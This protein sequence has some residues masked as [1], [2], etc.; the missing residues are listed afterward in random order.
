MPD[1][2]EDPARE[3]ASAT[4]RG[5]PRETQRSPGRS[6]Q[7]APTATLRA[8]HLQLRVLPSLTERV[9]G[10]ACLDLLGYGFRAD[11]HRA[12]IRDETSHDLRRVA[13]ALPC[14]SSSRPGQ[15]RWCR[16]STKRGCRHYSIE[17]LK[18]P[19]NVRQCRLRWSHHSAVRLKRSGRLRDLGMAWPG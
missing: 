18:S 16:R 11:G 10:L 6:H 12:S 3:C 2:Q 14:T 5:R 8:V 1:L 13:C 19:V 7:I 9:S 4:S 15:P 17:E